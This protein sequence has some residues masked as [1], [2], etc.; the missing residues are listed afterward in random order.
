MR[1][2]CRVSVWCGLGS[3]EAALGTEDVHTFINPAHADRCVLLERYMN[4]SEG[5]LAFSSST[6]LATVSALLVGVTVPSWQPKQASK[7]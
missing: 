5:V 1:A 6:S 4:P 3:S 7:Q 2:V